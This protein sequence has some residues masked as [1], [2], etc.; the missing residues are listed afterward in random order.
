MRSSAI[1]R[2]RER[3][4]QRDTQEADTWMPHP[5]DVLID[6]TAEITGA[7]RKVFA[8]AVI[9]R[10]FDERGWPRPGDAIRLEY[11]GLR[12]NKSGRE[13]KHYRID[14]EPG[15]ECRL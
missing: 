1:E 13:Y 6:E 10:H 11:V 7:P 14:T 4:E 12:T 9:K 5:G 3:A 15:T 8:A 2:L